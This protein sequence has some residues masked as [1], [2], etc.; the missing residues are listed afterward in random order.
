MQR[1][2]RGTIWRGLALIRV[3]RKT[4]PRTCHRNSDLNKEKTALGQN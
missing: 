4:P 2:L 3:V 1:K